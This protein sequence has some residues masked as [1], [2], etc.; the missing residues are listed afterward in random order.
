MENRNK[1][2]QNG[3]DLN[4]KEKV[5]RSR[6]KRRQV[7]R[8]GVVLCVGKE[9]GR[10]FNSCTNMRYKTS[11]TKLNKSESKKQANDYVFYH[12]NHPKTTKNQLSNLN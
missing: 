11:P 10:R 6:K 2:G 8:D 5:F 9:T 12:T 1:V 7:S 3:R 4:R